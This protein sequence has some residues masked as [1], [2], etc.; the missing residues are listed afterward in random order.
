MA[1]FVTKLL[2]SVSHFSEVLTLLCL[3]PAADMGPLSSMFTIYD[4]G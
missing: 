4:H 1:V 3:H 2:Q